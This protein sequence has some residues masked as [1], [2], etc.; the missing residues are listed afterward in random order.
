MSHKIWYDTMMKRNQI[1]QHTLDPIGIWARQPCLRPTIPYIV[2]Y[3]T[4][5]QQHHSLEEVMA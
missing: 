1:V 2:T 3:S 4:L 5:N